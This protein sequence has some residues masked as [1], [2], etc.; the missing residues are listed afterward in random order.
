MQ[1]VNNNGTG[2]LGSGSLADFQ[3][4][5]NASFGGIVHGA[6]EPTDPGQF[7]PG[8]AFLFFELNDQSSNGTGAQSEWHPDRSTF[9][10]QVGASWA[11]SVQ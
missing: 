3:T 4:S 9:L 6:N 10:G 1:A 7:K 5:D 8:G 2:V 11:S